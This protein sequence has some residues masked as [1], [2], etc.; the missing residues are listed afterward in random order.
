MRPGSTAGGTVWATASPAQPRSVTPTARA[1]SS[2]A[3]QSAAIQ[4]LPKT[5]HPAVALAKTQHTRIVKDTQPRHPVRTRLTRP[6]MADYQ[7][8]AI[9]RDNGHACWPDILHTALLA[10]RVFSADPLQLP[11]SVRD[12]GAKFWTPGERAAA[13]TA[14]RSSRNVKPGVTR[15]RKT[16]GLATPR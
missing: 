14:I 10:T 2:F 1:R 15:R 9:I 4:L 3:R 7:H 11:F 8:F 13:R 12:A 6:V 5:V 16:S